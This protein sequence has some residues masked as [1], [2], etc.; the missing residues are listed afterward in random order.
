M[1]ARVR[2]L[3][4]G[5]TRFLGRAV[6]A[7]ALDR[8]W[9]TTV[10]NRGRSGS[11]PGG[12]TEVHGDRRRLE[13]LERLAALG[14][15][16]V[17][18]DVPGVVPAEVRDAARVLAPLANRYVY[19]SSVSAYRDWPA[20]PVDEDSPVREGDPDLDVDSWE[21]GAGVYGGLKAGAE[22][23]VLREAGD[24][25]LIAR[26]GV[27]LG[28]WEYSGRLTWWLERI[29]RGGPFVAP[30]NPDV[31]IQPVDVRDVAAFLLDQ[32]A[33]GKAG[34]FNLA[35]PIGSAR[36]AGLLEAC[37]AATG[38]AARPVWVPD[39]AL[40]EAGLR[41][42]MQPPLWRT[43]PGTWRIDP[44]RALAAGLVP[45]PLAETVADTWAWMRTGARPFEDERAAKHGIPAEVE[46]VL[47]AA[48]GDGRGGEEHR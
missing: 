13:D 17:V 1:E 10:F 46:R 38:A 12:A 27:I 20:A 9:A 7:A 36:F 41:E 14:P 21:W 48:T 16:E 37:I 32:A 31:E 40:R 22:Q 25:A 28:P 15:W 26:P 8:G 24:R 4:L 2:V 47:L 29:A 44:G 45:R 19:V 39:A 3:V 33:A 6:A 18:V 42:W 5:G 23:A 30:S 43:A 11:P 35:A 34:I